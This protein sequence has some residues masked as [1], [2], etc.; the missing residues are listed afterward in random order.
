MGSPDKRLEDIVKGLSPEEKAKLV[1]EDLFRKEPV[2]TPW[3]RHKMLGAMSDDEGRRYNAVLDR[4]EK[5][6]SNIRT[7]GHLADRARRHLLMR[8]RALWYERALVELEEAIVFDPDVA[9]PLLVKN[10][11]LEPGRPLV[12]RVPLVTLRLGVW[13]KKGRSPA[14]KR[15]GVQL[16]ERVVEALSV[17]KAHLCQLAGEIKAVYRYIVE[18]SRAAGLDFMEG[19]AKMIVR[20]IAEYDR[21]LI[22]DLLQG[23]NGKWKDKSSERESIFPVERRWAL[24]WEEVEENEETAR[25]I[26]KDPEGWMPVSYESEVQELDGRFLEVMMDEAASWTERERPVRGAGSTAPA[27]LSLPGMSRD[28]YRELWAQPLTD[29]TDMIPHTNKP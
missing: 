24:V 3:N 26:R 13:G 8:D 29:G 12:L 16:D 7:L 4:F 9:N 10:A 6:K 5:L 28:W 1:I 15:S 14:G 11:N 27:M 25:R 18:E 19:L 17:H 22:E 20:P 23:D 21:P 2:L